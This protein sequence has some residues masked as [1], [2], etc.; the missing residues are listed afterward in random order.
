MNIYKKRTRSG[1]YRKIYEQHYGPIPK[2]EDGR[3]FEIHHVDGNP[4]N[5]SKENLVALT[6]QEHYD[7]HYSQGDFKACKLIVSQRMNKTPEELSE[8]ARLLTL[9]QIEDGTHNWM[10]R[11]DGS[12][13]SSD[14]VDNGTHNFL[15]GEIQRKS[16]HARVAD[17]THPFLDGK[18]GR[19][20][21]QKQIDDGTHPFLGG[22][23][24]RKSNHARVANGTHPAQILVSCLYCKKE[25][26]YTNFKRWHGDK[27]K[28]KK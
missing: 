18:I 26:G 21:N 14:R 25:T 5:N 22:E 1:N 4:E 7:I 9:K 17:G 15:G 20:A 11:V 3:T 27:C 10:K 24:Q 19:D 6:I 8:M 23:I 2:D 12:S 16:N 13:V 28:F